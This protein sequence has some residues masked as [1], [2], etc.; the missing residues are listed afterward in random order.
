M[1]DTDPALGTAPL[2]Q[3]Q[4]GAGTGERSVV[5]HGP[6]FAP[7]TTGDHSPISITALGPLRPV[8]DVPPTA[9][10]VG[11]DSY[12]P[13]FVG[14]SAELAELERAL[15]AGPG[16][17][18]QAVHGLGGIGKSAL[19]A[20]FALLHGREYTQVVWINAEDAASIEAGLRRFAI[21]LEPLL[22]ALTA[23]ALADRATQWLVAHGGWLLVLD[24]VNSA[25]EISALLNRLGGG[26]GRF[27]VTSRR[28][29][30]W[31]RVG[32]TAVRLGV[33]EP[34]EALTL[35]AATIGVAPSALDGG[36]RLCAELG[37]LPLAITQA[38]A[39]IAQNQH[40]D[41]FGARSYL[42]L[43]REHPADL[44]AAGDLDTEVNSERTIARIWRVTLDRIADPPLAGQ[45]LR[46]LAW[47]AP[48]AI[49]VSLLD[50]MAPEPGLEL[51]I[52]RLTA[53][54]MLTY[55]RPH[56]DAGP[57]LAVHRLVQAVS[58]TPDPTDPQHGTEAIDLARDQATALLAAALPGEFRDPGTWATWRRL[59]PHIN[60]LAQYS[61]P[62]ADTLDTVGVLD[63]AGL[64]LLNQG[65]L[66]RAINYLERA[67]RGRRR[68][69]GEDDPKTLASR[70]GLAKA[71][72][73]AG[74]Y[75][76]AIPLHEQALA[77]RIRVLGN[78]HP[79]TLMTGED[80]ANAYMDAGDLAR[81]IPLHEQTLADRI[82]V[83]GRDHPDT[84]SSQHNL[85]YAYSKAGDPG[86][87]IPLY[88]QNLEDSRRILGEDHPDTLATRNNLAMSYQ[89][90]GDPQ[91]AISIHLQALEDF[92]RVLGEDHPST[93]V[94]RNNLGFAYEAA[95]DPQRAV[96][97]HE[98]TLADRLRVLGEDH[99]HVLGSRNNLANAY[100]DAGEPR[101]AITLYEEALQN[102]HR[103]LENDNPQV[104]IVRNDL[105]VAYWRAGETD[106]AVRLLEQTLADRLRLLGGDHP[107][108]LTTRNDIAGTYLYTDDPGRAIPLFEQLLD[109]CR[110][111]LGDMHPL[112]KA[113]AD[114]LATA[115]DVTRA[116]LPSPWRR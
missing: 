11:I 30:G 86:R 29:V 53:Y 46:V 68:L 31:G 54:S 93:L 82:R 40:E 97:L 14:R 74:D 64:F 9:G 18:I 52:G 33:L 16:A 80:L 115:T 10:P 62:G 87:A 113:V 114:N 95:G 96:P 26:T 42:R 71:Y 48:D 85:A 17:V 75:A 110:L 47:Y 112:T 55:S 101:R 103:F 59:I 36:D 81:A 20:R 72:M 25:G 60:A 69:L 109:D 1:S 49:P 67:H 3:G 44:Y 99:P 104:L 108:T 45:V 12:V 70:N 23:E 39:Y 38:G 7:I 41:G 105:A 56:T 61:T 90:A 116:Q 94:S 83:L 66:V 65:D 84:L 37:F 28:A 89:A 6:N 34:G 4:I 15:A 78:D 111:V 19:A 22:G 77:D 5:A 43:L 35:L 2:S 58:R 106:R 21:A 102:S 79:D 76:R 63:R 100:R 32:A 50:G 51:A 91:R 92:R 98:Q 24:N 107:D 73:E 13:L 27:L 88:E 8:A 57:Q